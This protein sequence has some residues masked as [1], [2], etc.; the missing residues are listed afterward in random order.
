MHYRVVLEGWGRANYLLPNPKMI[1]LGSIEYCS[2][3]SFGA[4]GKSKNLSGKNVRGSGYCFSSCSIP[5]QNLIKIL[6]KELEE[7]IYHRFDMTIEPAGIVQ[8]P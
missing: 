4:S 7:S 8:S 3:L 1:S 6:L 5:L 2:N